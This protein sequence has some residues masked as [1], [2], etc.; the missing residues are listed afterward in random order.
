MTDTLNRKM[1]N[2]LGAEATAKG[3]TGKDKGTFI[4]LQV[5]KLKLERKGQRDAVIQQRIKELPKEILEGLK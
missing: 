1:R 4:N 5:D 2:E 3:L